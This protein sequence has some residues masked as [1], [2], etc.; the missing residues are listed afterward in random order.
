MTTGPETR[1]HGNWPRPV[2]RV[3]SLTSSIAY[4]RDQ[5]GFEVD[6]LD[7]SGSV[8]TCAQVSRD[9]LDLILDENAAFPKASPPSVLSVTLDDSPTSPALE[10]LHRELVRSGGRVVRS[11]FKVVWDAQV[12]EMDIAD[13]D[14]NVLMFWGHVRET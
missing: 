3:A 13:L 10:E 12:H 7:Q 6:W 14:G 5:L 9:G 11:P 2:F 4:Y 1:P 8:P